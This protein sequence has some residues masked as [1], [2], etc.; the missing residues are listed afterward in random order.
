M[1]VDPRTA[2][3]LAPFATTL[4]DVEV[5]GSRRALLS[6]RDSDA[7]QLWL[8]TPG[9]TVRRLTDCDDAVSLG[10]F[11]PS[12]DAILYAVDDG[13]DEYRQL[14]LVDLDTG[15]QRALTADPGAVHQFGGFSPDGAALAYAST[16]A[17]GVDFD[18]YVQALDEAAPALVLRGQGQRTVEAWTLDGRALA[19]AT[20]HGALEQELHRVDL[21][22]GAVRPL[23]PGPPA[24]ARN[25][26]FLPAGDL[27]VA[28]D[29]GREHVGIAR[30]DGDGGPLDWRLATDADV[31]EFALDRGKRRLAAVL[32]RHGWDVVEVHDLADDDGPPRR[33]V[34]EGVVQ[35]LHWQ[36][37]GAAVLATFS[38]PTRPPTPWRFDLESG[39]HG[40]LGEPSAS[41]EGVAPELVHVRSFDG[42]AVPAFLFT[43][44][45]PSPV[46]GRPAVV[47]VHGG[48]EAQWRPTFQGEIQAMVAR[49]WAVLAP[50]VR[51]STGYGRTYSGLDDR[52]RRGDA[53]LDL[54]A[55]G[56]WLGARPGI[57]PRRL[58]IMGHSYGG[59]MT[60]A[61]LTRHPELWRTGVDIFGFSDFRTLLRD[62][63]GYRRNHRAREY[64]A[65][66]AI[67]GELSPLGAMAR[68]QAPLFVAHGLEDVRVPAS[69]SRRL[70][71]L[72]EG[73]GHDVTSRFVA[74]AGHGFVKRSDRLA[75]Y[76]DALAFLE[77]TL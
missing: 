41:P 35:G 30:L 5:A 11:R 12:G 22:T 31:E 54:E 52:E 27:L 33:F 18:V 71:A 37:D 74:R 77:R 63:A 29:Q 44:P 58:A 42:R 69:E 13:G 4:A 48:P 68:L 72:L 9:G 50:N 67:L 2:S 75:V 60:L 19:I 46:G 59:F 34:T 55:V 57:D 47:L 66:P 36:P 26:V 8:E 7:P 39:R 70:L 23:L 43:A 3:L 32:N 53:L 51:G 61:T 45:E 24:V 20:A 21:A 40:P 14:H 64:E 49:G 65:D 15:R 10:K 56:R 6:N 76:G 16:A 25:V 38:S 1:T 17:N 73:R 62:T 28:T